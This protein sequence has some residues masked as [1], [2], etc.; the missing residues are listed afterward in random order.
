MMNDIMA[1]K[2]MGQERTLVGVQV[3]VGVHVGVGIV[4]Q[5]VLGTDSASRTSGDGTL[6]M[7]LV[8]AIVVFAEMAVVVAVVS[9][10]VVASTEITLVVRAGRLVMTSIGEANMIGRI[11]HRR[12]KSRVLRGRT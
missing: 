1:G 3:G 9:L 6:I 11:A 4:V 12:M 8:P 5:V 7:V 2:L 10:A